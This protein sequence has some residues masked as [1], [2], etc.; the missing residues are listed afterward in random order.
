MLKE[1]AFGRLSMTLHGLAQRDNF[2]F[3]EAKQRGIPIS[4]GQGGGYAKPSE[5]TVEAHIQTYSILK[6]VYALV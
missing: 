4:L 5:I 6:E 1:D 3:S 2:V